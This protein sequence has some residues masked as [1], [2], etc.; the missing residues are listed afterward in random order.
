MLLAA[1][2]RPYE[3]SY[4][5]GAVKELKEVSSTMSP[6]IRISLPVEE[7]SLLDGEAGVSAATVLKHLLTA[8]IL[9][10][11]CHG[12]QDNS[13]PLDSGFIMRDRKLTISELM[14]LNLPRAFLAFLSACETAK[15]DEKQSDEV[16]HL[17]ASMLFTGFK[18]VVGTMW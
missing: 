17:A 11:A 12:K 9:H 10:L 14:T 8:D 5:K 18:S 7:D 1:V 3:G 2:P 6:G 16:I 4:L 13:S 15:G